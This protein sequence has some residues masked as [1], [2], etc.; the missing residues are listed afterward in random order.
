MK[1]IISVLL[2][3]MMLF[4]AVFANASI[5]EFLTET[6]NNYTADYSVSIT[7]DNCDEVAALLEELEMPE[8]VSYFVDIKALMQSLFAYSGTMKLQADF[9]DSFDKIK[10]ALTAESSQK[11]DVNPNLSVGVDGKVGMWLNLD[12]TDAENP[13][14]D[15]IYSYP[16]LNKYMVMSAADFLEESPEA[17]EMIKSIYNKEY[18]DNLSKISAEMFMK[19]ATIKSRGNQYTVTIDNEGFAALVDDVIKYATETMTQYTGEDLGDLEFPSVKNWKFLGEGG[20]ESIYTLRSGKLSAEETTIDFSIELD[21][22]YTA[23]TGEE[24]SYISADTID[25]TFKVSANVTNIGRTNV[26]FPEITEENSFTLDDLIPD[27]EYEDYEESDY[28]EYP[29]WYA[30]GYCSQLP[31]IDGDVYIPLRMTIESA[32]ADSAAIDYNDGVVTVTS[33]YFPG[34]K[35]LTMTIGTD[36][37]YTDGVEHTLGN[38]FT[39]DGSTYVNYK[40][41]TD[42]FGWEINYAQYDLLTNEYSY[43][44]WTI[45]F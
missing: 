11:V 21:Q 41:F 35:T 45:A 14:I 2:A 8:E 33:E 36:K 4:T 15:I 5:P 29:H 19:Y 7:F 1:K 44:F 3:T 24:W 13:V 31:V 18:V 43:S 42:V 10:L 17:I 26:V 16:F 40:L 23:I 22:I 38:I 25:F 30:D 27:Y 39:I 20:I 32:Y 6:Y 9:N 37:V 12:L 34:F 28:A